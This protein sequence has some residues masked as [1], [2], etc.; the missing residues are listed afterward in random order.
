MEF[1]PATLQEFPATY[2]SSVY[3]APGDKRKAVD[4]MRAFPS[5]TVIDL[6]AIL[7]QVR[8]VMNKASL[9][10]ETVFLFTLLAGLAVLWAALLSS[11]D[12]RRFES[13]ILRTLGASRRRV[14]AGVAAEFAAIGLLAGLLASSGA[15]LIAWHLAT[16]VFHLPYH[17]NP[18]IWLSGPLLGLLIVGGSG[19]LATRSVVA[20]APLSVLRAH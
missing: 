7:S 2:I 5:V 8:D 6:D 13:A 19:L 11:R 16:N 20:H 14:F 9:A 18:A 17:F 12:E 3:L 10:V 15:G 1:T 4:L